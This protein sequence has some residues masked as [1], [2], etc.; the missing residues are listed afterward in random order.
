MDDIKLLKLH[1][2]YSNSELLELAGQKIKDL[3]IENGKL[4]S[5][6]AEL[7]YQLSLKRKLSP[8]QI[9]QLK[10]KGWV[11]EI[12]TDEYIE[13]LKLQIAGLKTR[14]EGSDRVKKLEKELEFW[15]NKACNLVV[16]YE[17]Q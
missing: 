6:I 11:Q 12:L 3:E 7:K 17:S 16:K 9:N 4:K 2:K 14:L 13:M 8:E 10:T 1:R 5:E 15:R